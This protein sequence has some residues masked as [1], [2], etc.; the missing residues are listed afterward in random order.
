MSF[1]HCVFPLGKSR[2]PFGWRTDSDV[3][4]KVPQY[5]AGLAGD[6]FPGFSVERLIEEMCPAVT[7]GST[8]NHKPDKGVKPGCAVRE[9]AH[10]HTDAT[11]GSDRP[12][13]G[14]AL[15]DV[16]FPLRNT[17]DLRFIPAT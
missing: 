3:R 12:P 14:I 9:G 8:S 11:I 6:A 15:L 1:P 4:H 10:G 7:P 17:A 13:V 16:S 5:V 2:D